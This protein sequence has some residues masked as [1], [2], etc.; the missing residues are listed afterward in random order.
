MKNKFI[1]KVVIYLTSVLIVGVIVGAV[2][3]IKEAKEKA[4]L[5]ATYIEPMPV[6]TEAEMETL[7]DE[8][9]KSDEMQ[10]A[11]HTSEAGEEA[12]EETEDIQNVSQSDENGVYEGCPVDFAGMWEINEDVY[13]W[14]TIPGTNID[15]PILQHDTD[16]TYYLNYNI[17]GS[18]GFPGCIYTENLN[19]KDFLDNN[20]IIYGHDLK[21]G[22]MFSQLHKFK[23]SA[24]FEEHKKVYI[25]TPEKELSYTIFAAYLYDDRHLMYS[26]DFADS[27]VYATYLED[28]LNM[29]SMNALIRE[30]VTVTAQDKIITL[31]TCAR[32]QP[33]KRYLVQAVL[34][35]PE[36]VAE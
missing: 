15:Y 14:I 33:D 8:H 29:R 24:F 3:A 31:E 19:S 1:R 6:M 5:E 26:F 27:Q 4:D 25:Y 21:A 28:V 34:D 17:D 10:L 22:T 20:T 11:E 32:N 9:K 35:R 2:F 18:Y 36:A 16:N 12:T 13:A 23:D 30:D 7:Y